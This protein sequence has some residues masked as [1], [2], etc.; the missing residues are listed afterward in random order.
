MQDPEAVP[1]NI[2][3]LNLFGTFVQQSLPECSV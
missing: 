1:R 3:C 2:I